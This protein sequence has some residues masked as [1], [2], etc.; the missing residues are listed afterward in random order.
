MPETTPSTRRPRR[1]AALPAGL[2]AVVLSL[3]AGLLLAPAASACSC[4]QPDPLRQMQSADAV[5]IAEPVSSRSLDDATTAP[6]EWTMAV[7]EVLVGDVEIITE[8]RTGRGGPDECGRTFEA[9]GEPVGIVA[10]R[11]PEEGYLA[12]ISCST[13]DG[14]ALRAAAAELG[15][16]S[17][18]PSGVP[19]GPTVVVGADDGG[20]P[21]VASSHDDRELDDLEDQ[22]VLVRG[23][24]A[25]LAIA[26]ATTM[27]VAY[28]GSRG[29]DA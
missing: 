14:A 13:S 27:I 5:F 2:A 1:R 20:G 12:A 11:D 22:V 24:V 15:I 25:L 16:V 4:V 3:G 23:I 28:T 17:H 29:D 26:L 19:E 7:R 18:E 6:I 8:I 21:V 9:I 10:N